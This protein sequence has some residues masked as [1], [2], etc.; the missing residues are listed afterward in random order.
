M[1]SIEI[2]RKGSDFY[3][4]MILRDFFLWIWRSVGGLAFLLII[5][6]LP[7]PNQYLRAG[8]YLVAAGLAITYIGA[9]FLV[10]KN[11]DS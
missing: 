7:D 11:Q 5:A 10:K 3:A 2:G 6:L 1:S 4:T 8:L 9:Y